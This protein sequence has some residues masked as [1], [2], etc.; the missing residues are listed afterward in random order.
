MITEATGQAVDL[1]SGDRGEFSVWVDDVVVA[2]KTLLGYPA[3]AEVIA[4]VKDALAG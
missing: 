1:E 2:K 4:R 3:E